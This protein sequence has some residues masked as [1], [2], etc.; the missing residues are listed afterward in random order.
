MAS[1][2]DRLDRIKSASAERIPAEAQAVMSA[3]VQRLIDSGAAEA[4]L[5]EEA[6]WPGFKLPD[7][8]GNIVESDALLGRGP[9]IVTFFRGHW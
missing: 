4:A 9:L 6:T 5:G 3:E 2:Q 8:D 7:S 1:L